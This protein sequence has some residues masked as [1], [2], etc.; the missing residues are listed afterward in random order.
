MN[1]A[2][3]RLVL[4]ITALHKWIAVCMDISTAFL[5]AHIIDREVFLNP[6]KLRDIGHKLLNLHK[7]VY[8][9][10]DALSQW[11][12][13]LQDAFPG[14]GREMVELERCISACF[15]GKENDRF[16]VAVAWARVD[17]IFFCGVCNL[18][19]FLRERIRDI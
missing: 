2:V 9:L 16:L 17:A 14:I 6:L 10:D 7:R 11:F 3:W 13:A 4:S 5:Q 1:R 15:C 8:G 12:K 18:I 19:D